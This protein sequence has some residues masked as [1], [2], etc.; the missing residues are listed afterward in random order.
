[1]A[2]NKAGVTDAGSA[3]KEHE[4]VV[5]SAKEVR[6]SLVQEWNKGVQRDYARVDQLLN[7]A[8]ILLTKLQ[9]YLPL[10][11]GQHDE[12]ELELARELLELGARA[13]VA[14]MAVNKSD[15]SEDFDRYL[16]QL[17]HYY[18]DLKM[19]NPSN[20]MYEMLGMNLLKLL[21]QNRIME[22]HLELEL[23]IHSNTAQGL[24]DPYIKKAVEMEQY[25]TE[26]RYNKILALLTANEE[27]SKAA[28]LKSSGF[29][30]FIERVIENSREVIA[31]VMEKAYDRLEKKFALEALYTK[32]DLLVKFAQDRNWVIGPDNYVYFPKT[33]LDNEI[34]PSYQLVQD[35][36]QYAKNLDTII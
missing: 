35:G 21:S 10:A 23:F 30:H 26:G 22:F 14:K 8:K 31:D 36:L 28:G 9:A 18:F 17:K 2:V 34:L 3:A 11:L 32:E 19:Q 12:S 25:L 13:S 15:E 6:K 20:Y 1:M 33:D 5:Q 4:K 29:R 27:Q 24:N 16:A 7:N